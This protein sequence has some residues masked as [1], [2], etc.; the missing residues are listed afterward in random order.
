VRPIRAKTAR[1]YP[2]YCVNPRPAFLQKLVF[3]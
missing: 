3:L 1:R 2:N